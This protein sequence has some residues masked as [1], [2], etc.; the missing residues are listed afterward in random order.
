MLRKPFIPLL[1]L[2]S[3]TSCSLSTTTSNETLKA[4]FQKFME[5]SKGQHISNVIW[6]LGPPSNVISHETGGKIYFWSQQSQKQVPQYSLEI[7]PQDSSQPKITKGKMK[8]N[9]I[10]QQWEWESTTVSDPLK[11]VL[12]PQFRRKL[13]GY[14][15]QSHGYLIRFYV[16][17]DETVF[18]GELKLW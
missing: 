8:W 9:P 3:I 12:M 6:K 4:N 1:L 2:I 7:V 17:A 11:P 10:L 18:Y 16:D 5:A 15:T 14:T 13:T